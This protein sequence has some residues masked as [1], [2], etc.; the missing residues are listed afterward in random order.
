MS[1]RTKN[2]QQT[3]EMSPINA[4]GPFVSHNETPPTIPGE[5]PY[6]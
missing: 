5:I 6:G 2:K 4:I 3:D 1:N